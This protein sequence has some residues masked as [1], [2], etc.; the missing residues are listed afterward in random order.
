MNV[1]EAIHNIHQSLYC[2]KPLE[3]LHGRLDNGS[4]KCVSSFLKNLLGAFSEPLEN[5]EGTF[6]KASLNVVIFNF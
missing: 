2:V 6:S 3:N 1:F 5:P 4:L